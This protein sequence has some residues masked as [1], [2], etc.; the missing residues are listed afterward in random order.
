MQI[1]AKSPN[2]HNRLYMQAEPL[3][4]DLVKAIDQNEVGPDDD[5]KA[6]ARKMADEFKWEVG[7]ARKIWAFGCPPDGKA[8][9]LG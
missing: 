1:I 2:K 8:N 7:D 3:G 5:V 6:R 4:D 9:L